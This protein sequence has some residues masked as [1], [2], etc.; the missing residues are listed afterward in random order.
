MTKEI[1]GLDQFA[2]GAPISVELSAGLTAQV[3]E[4]VHRFLRLVADTDVRDL[5]PCTNETPAI[6]PI[7]ASGTYP[8]LS[9]PGGWHKETRGNYGFRVINPAYVPVAEIPSNSIIMQPASHDPS[10]LPKGLLREI[11]AAAREI[12]NQAMAEFPLHEVGLGDRV[13]YSVSRMSGYQPEAA[14][15]GEEGENITLVGHIDLK[16]LATA[17]LFASGPG[18]EYKDPAT[19]QFREPS[20]RAFLFPSEVAGRDDI[21]I[22]RPCEHR[23]N[24]DLMNEGTYA[25]INSDIAHALSRA[26]LARVSLTQLMFPPLAKVRLK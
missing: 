11:S 3:E 20:T 5:V 6:Y 2:L 16:G 4:Q 18:F 17:L 10:I 13:S 7:D 12:E 9:F 26:G 21:A 22:A 15:R 24:G 25:D 1:Y 14:N 19:Q 23:V 8:Y